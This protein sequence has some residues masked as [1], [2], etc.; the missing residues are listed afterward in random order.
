MHLR[1]EMAP[2]AEVP[3]LD[4]HSVAG[5]LQHP[6]DP[7]RPPGIR[8]YIGNEEIHPVNAYALHTRPAH[9]HDHTQDVA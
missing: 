2:S 6:G 1:D 5:I 3:R 9:I 4:Q 7:L 8:F